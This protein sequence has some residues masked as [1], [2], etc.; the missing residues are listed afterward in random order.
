[1]RALPTI[2]SMMQAMKEAHE[3][4]GLAI[5]AVNLDENRADAARF[6]AQYHPSF[7]VRYDRNGASVMLRGGIAWPL[8]SVQAPGKSDVDLPRPPIHGPQ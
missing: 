2:P 6:L 4:E 3:S 5:V 7:D 1:M 8:V